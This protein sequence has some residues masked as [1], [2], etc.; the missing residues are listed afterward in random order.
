MDTE[1]LSWSTNNSAGAF[2]SPLKWTVAGYRTN[3]NT[4]YNVGTYGYYWNSS[5]YLTNSRVLRFYSNSA[6]TLDF[7]R[8]TGMSVRCVKD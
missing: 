7:N 5:V 8:A 2:A 1:R 4:L 6:G 3:G